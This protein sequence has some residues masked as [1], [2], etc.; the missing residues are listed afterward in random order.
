MYNKLFVYTKTKVLESKSHNSAIFEQRDILG[1]DEY[2]V[3]HQFVQNVLISENLVK[4]KFN[5]NWDPKTK[6][7][8]ENII[9]LVV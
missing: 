3:I 8:K 5:E 4:Y 2:L 7:Y 6:K 1:S 9:G